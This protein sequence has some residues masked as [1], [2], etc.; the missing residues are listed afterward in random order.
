MP[1]HVLHEV[2]RVRHREAKG[3]EEDNGAL[4][5]RSGHPEP[6]QASPEHE[7]LRQWSHDVV[8]CGHP[9]APPEFH[10]LRTAHP[11]SQKM[12]HDRAQKQCGG[13][14][15]APN[16]RPMQAPEREA[17]QLTKGVASLLRTCILGHGI[18]HGSGAEAC[19]H[20]GEESPLDGACC[21]TV[22]VPIAEELPEMEREDEDQ[23]QSDRAHQRH[24]RFHAHHQQ[25]PVAPSSR[26]SS[27]R[28]R[29]GC[30]HGHLGRRHLAAKKAPAHHRALACVGVRAPGVAWGEL[31]PLCL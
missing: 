22:L 12:L 30:G 6:H 9:G 7:L 28:R 29:R 1:P 16:A 20:G 8:P 21:I 23:R 3:A 5:E 25:R 15:Q 26:S 18:D 11:H 27:S 4:G 17:Q 19:Q 13:Q 24:A 31:E 2:V 14:R 10:E